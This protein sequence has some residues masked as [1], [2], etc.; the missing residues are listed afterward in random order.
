[1]ETN[2]NDVLE[3]LTDE[4]KTFLIKVFV[5]G[6][7]AMEAALRSEDIQEMFDTSKS[8]ILSALPYSFREAVKL[9]DEIKN[10]MQ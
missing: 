4:Q 7:D 5:Y 8:E 10:I 3:Y 2:F 1:M 6:V 9:R